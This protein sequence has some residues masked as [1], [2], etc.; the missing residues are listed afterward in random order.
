M[1]KNQDARYVQTSISDTHA[2]IKIWDQFAQ[3]VFDITQQS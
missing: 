1:V 3:I 2:Q